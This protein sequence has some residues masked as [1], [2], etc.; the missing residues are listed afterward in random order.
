ATE[1][2]ARSLRHGDEIGTPRDVRRQRECLAAEAAHVLGGAL[3]PHRV[4]LG[5]DDVG[6]EPRQL[7]RG[8][9]PDSATAAGDNGDASGA[10]AVVHGTHGPGVYRGSRDGM[11]DAR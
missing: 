11:L 10:L 8:G 6:A 5:D 3:G 9:A 7:E 2:A 1:L 4:E